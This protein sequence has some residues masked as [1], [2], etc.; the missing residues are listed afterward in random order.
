MG[1]GEINIYIAK[2]E[3]GALPDGQRQIDTQFTLDNSEASRNLLSGTFGGALDGA[4]NYITVQYIKN[5]QR[6]TVERSKSMLS[7]LM[8]IVKNYVSKSLNEGINIYGELT[9]D[10]IGVNNAQVFM[11]SASNIALAL[12]SPTGAISVAYN[13]TK[14]IIER[15]I[16]V[17]KAN[18]K[19]QFLSQGLGK[20][21]TN[22]GRYY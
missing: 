5:I 17:K 4:N 7:V 18:D 10:M 20:I 6:Q 2:N 16:E 12:S 13:T 11:N 8:P 9:G 21:T 19:A 15:N 14:S 1:Y 22:Y 3:Q